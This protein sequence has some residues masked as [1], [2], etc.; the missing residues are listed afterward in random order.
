[1]I[2]NPNLADLMH[3][4]PFWSWIGP[5][6]PF[7]VSLLYL[8]TMRPDLYSN[9]KKFVV[10]LVRSGPD[11]FCVSSCGGDACPTYTH[12]NVS[13]QDSQPEET[14]DGPLSFLR[15]EGMMIL[16]RRI[17]GVE[18]VRRNFALWLIKSSRAEGGRNFYKELSFPRSTSPR[19]SSRQ[20]R[21]LF[22]VLILQI[23][24]FFGFSVQ[25]PPH[26]SEPICCV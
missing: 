20:S 10:I 21:N 1:M 14:M 25:V 11:M 23:S 4:P 6:R 16:E 3:H 13:L 17:L 5:R 8:F 26:I 18:R 12:T 2:R 19:I 15:M 24:A 9:W 22:L 7:W